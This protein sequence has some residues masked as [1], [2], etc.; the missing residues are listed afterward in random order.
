MVDLS[1]LLDV[2]LVLCG[3]DFRDL[4][5]GWVLDLLLGLV[6]LGFFVVWC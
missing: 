5:D 3:F 4:A 1:G 6:G 2:V